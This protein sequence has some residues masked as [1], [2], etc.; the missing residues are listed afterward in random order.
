MPESRLRAERR[1]PGW[2][3]A[4]KENRINW[5]EGL[6]GRGTRENR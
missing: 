5:G 6:S 1:D 4:S 3:K 2:R